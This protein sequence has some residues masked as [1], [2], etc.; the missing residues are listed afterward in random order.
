MPPPRALDTVDAMAGHRW[1]LIPLALLV[2]NCGNNDSDGDD[3]ACTPG[4][5]I[6]CIGQNGC[7]GYQ[8]CK[9]DGSGYSGCVCE[10][11]TATGGA[12]TGG[13]GTGGTAMGT[14]GA[15]AGSGGNTTGGHDTGGRDTGGAQASAG[16]GP[17][18][19][20]PADMNDWTLPEYV[21]ARA[22]QE[23]CTVAQIEEYME[24]HCHFG[25]CEDYEAG[26]AHEACGECL[27]PQPIDGAAY[28]PIIEVTVG[29]LTSVE[30]NSAGC[31]ELAGD[32]ECAASVRALDACAREACLRTCFPSDSEEYDL[33]SACKVAA[34]GGPC[35][36][37]VGPAACLLP[38]AV[39]LCSGTDP[40]VQ[41][42]IAF[43]G[44]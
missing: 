11:D 24:N 13:R 31:V 3:G 17:G 1:L 28:G 35:A 40:F 18:S 42:A 26:G 6:G 44:E 23:V 19:C 27:A 16:D 5:S 10:G 33:Y 2:V 39:S 38:A 7:S 34:R 30:T 12:A 37:Y 29:T 22:A 21:P 9:A 20:E 43:C 25:G 15:T 41:T 14:A 36:E 32:A 4:R 8:E